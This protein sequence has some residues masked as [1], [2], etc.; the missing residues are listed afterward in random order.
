MGGSIRVAIDNAE[1]GKRWLIR[2]QPLPFLIGRHPECNLCLSLPEISRKHALIFE[3]KGELWI[4]EFGS[5]NGTFINRSR[6]SN[7][8]PLH[9]GDVLHFSSLEFRVAYKP[10]VEQYT[11]QFDIDGTVCKSRME[12]SHEFSE[13]EEDFL[14]MLR[15]G[16]V[17]TNFQPVFSLPEKKVVAYEALGRGAFASLPESPMPLFSLARSLRKEIELSEMFRNV[18]V[19]RAVAIGNQ[20]IFFNTLPV[21]MN[22]SSLGRSLSCLRETAPHLPL[23]MEVHEA[24]ATYPKLMR[25][26]RS[27]LTQMDMRLLYDDFGAGRARLLE[28]IKVPPDILKFDISLIRCPC[29][30]SSSIKPPFPSDHPDESIEFGFRG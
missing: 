28:I 1:Q 6:I 19:R 4:K 10:I 22:I 11:G 30:K 7:E 16:A 17:T 2:L 18:A 20:P 5:T 15:L 24:A 29:K 25:E 23:A 21:E 14:S 27:L 13:Q 9:T 12:L 8:Q 26:V 3:R